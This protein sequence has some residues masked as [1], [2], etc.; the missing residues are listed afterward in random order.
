MTPARA[1][2]DPAAA[3]PEDAR[4]PSW[5]APGAKIIAPLPDEPP[6]PPPI[7][8]RTHNPIDAFIAAEWAK[9]RVSPARIV[10]DDV[11]VRRAYLDIAGVIPTLDDLGRHIG[12]RRLDRDALVDELLASPRYADHWTTFWGDLLREQTAIRGTQPFAFRDY[13]RGNLRDNKRL[14]QWVIE[15]LMAEGDAGENPAAGFFLAH[16]GSPDELTITVSQVFLGTQLRCAQCHDHKFEPWLQ[17]DF[18][19][20][21]GFWAGTRAR[22]ARTIEV[23]P[24]G[25][26][27]VRDLPIHAIKERSEGRGRFLTG[28]VSPLGTGRDA[29]AELV[30]SE[31]NP[32]FA[33]V[34]VNRIWAKMMGVGLVDPVDRFA[35]DNPPSHPELLDWLARAFIDGGYDLQHVIRL[36]CTSRT[37]QLATT[38]GALPERAADARLFQRMPLRR[39][40]AEQL[41]DSVLQSSGRLGDGGGRWQPAIEK[42]YPAP[43]QSFLATFG[44]H[45]RETLHERVTQATIPQALE[46]LNGDFVNGAVRLDADHPVTGWLRSGAGRAVTV[47]RLFLSTLTR[48]P[49]SDELRLAERFLPTGGDARDAWADLHWALINTREFMF[50]P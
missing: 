2:A 16:D 8:L 49:T 9:H 24:P 33:R 21:R 45:D 18:N 29:L 7:D 32:Y 40:T 4:A 11:F 22:R 25:R 26:Q 28:A 37:Y 15:M 23:T 44:S 5:G 30:T 19:G 13:I 42:R 41:H 36:I 47:R 43:A 17:D 14:D 35:V 46:L 39:M 20:M 48:E 3:A 10:T 27:M 38:G 34:A 6:I 12:G 1:A 31:R 50:I